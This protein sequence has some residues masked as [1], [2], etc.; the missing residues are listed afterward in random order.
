[1]R[2]LLESLYYYLERKLEIVDEPELLMVEQVRVTG[3]DRVYPL[4]EKSRLIC[5]LANRKTLS[6]KMLDELEAAGYVINYK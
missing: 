4:C 2:R 5:R 6:D 3:R 1:M